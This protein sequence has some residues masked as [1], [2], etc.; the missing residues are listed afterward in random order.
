MRSST[1]APPRSRLRRSGARRRAGRRGAPANRARRG[2]GSSRSASRAAIGQRSRRAK[3]TARV[4][5]LVAPI[6]LFLP[7]VTAVVVPVGLPEAGLVVVEELDTS[8]PLRALPE[9][10]VRNEQAGRP[11]VHGVERLA[12]ELVR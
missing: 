2:S 4:A 1:T 10:K 11:A 5:Q 12:V 3:S 9:V 8:H 7:R 6:P